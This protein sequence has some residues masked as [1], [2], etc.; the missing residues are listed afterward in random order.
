MRGQG[1]SVQAQRGGRGMGRVAP[2]ARRQTHGLQRVC[3]ARD[4]GRHACRGPSEGTGMR[5]MQQRRTYRCAGGDPLPT[6]SR[7]RAGVLR[8]P[9]PSGGRATRHR[10]RP[11]STSPSR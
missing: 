4:V 9:S 1:V 11:L 3:R 5:S 7:H 10:C 6:D 2:G 8:A